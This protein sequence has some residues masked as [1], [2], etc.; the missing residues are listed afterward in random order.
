MFE[1]NAALDAQLARELDGISEALAGEFKAFLV[2]KLS[3]PG[4]GVHWPG[5]PN[6]SSAPGQYPAEQSGALVQ[7]IDARREGDH[8]EVGSFDAPPEAFALEYPS[9]PGSPITRQSDHGARPWLSKA[10]TDPDLHRRL[11]E[12]IE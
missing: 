5:Q 11:E 6:P 12:V 10:L 3:G 8:W 9:P 1:P 2:E 4:S 7:S